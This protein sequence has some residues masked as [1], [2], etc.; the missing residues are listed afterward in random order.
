MTLMPDLSVVEEDVAQI[1]DQLGDALQRM[2]GKTL[3]VAGAGGFLPS[4]FLDVMSYANDHVL[5]DP[6][7]LVAVDNHSTGLAERTAHL[8]ERTDLR[9]IEHDITQPIA[10]D[11]HIDYIIHGA[12]IASPPVYRRFP[13]E[14]LDVNS[15]GTKHLLEMAKSTGAESVLYLSSSEIY[16]DPTEGNIPTPESYRGNVSCTGPRACYDESKRLAETL[17][18]I[19]HREYDVPVKVVRPFNV[20]GPGLR[21]DDQRII[22]DFVRNALAGDPIVIFSDGKATRS[23]CYISDAVAAMLL[24]LLNGENGEAY[25]VGN[26]EEH[27]VEQVAALVTTVAGGSGGIRFEHSPDPDY[28]VDNPVRRVPDLTKITDA[29][30]WEPSIPLDEGLRRTMRWYGHQTSGTAMEPSQ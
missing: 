24:V 18:G 3:L 4:Y 28:T 30:D 8:R 12:S 25:N 16:G 27:S 21:L 15:N 14:T 13:L 2:G 23:F 1:C 5:S 10:I 17:C 6:C 26:P 22:P 20:Y 11:I 19:Y 7:R 29:L 9:F